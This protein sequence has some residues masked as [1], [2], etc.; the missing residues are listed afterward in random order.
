MSLDTDGSK[1]LVAPYGG[2][3]VSLLAEGEGRE[4]L[5]A[6]AA[7]LPRLQLT[8]RA[9]CDLELL[10]TGGFSPLSRFMNRADYERVLG[11][12]RL[13]DGTLFPM[14]VTLT[15]KQGEPVRLDEEVA[16]TD[17]FNNPL[18]VLRAEEVFKWD[19]AR[20]ARLAYGTQDLR[21]PLVAEMNSWGDLCVS[22]ELRVI[23]LPR[24]YDFKPLRQTPAQVRERL[25]A[26]G[27]AN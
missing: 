6:R 22:G 24:Y 13:S 26:L 7:G 5:L 4:E 17:Q 27:H 18:A 21:P 23:Q 3:L 19:R 15:F 25:A 8:P 12:M 16:L 14:P 10:A 20:E 2:R 1:K 9:L 11:E